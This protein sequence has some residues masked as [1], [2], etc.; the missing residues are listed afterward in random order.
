MWLCYRPVDREISRNFL[1]DPSQ[2]QVGHPCNKTIQNG[3]FPFSLEK[4]KILF[5]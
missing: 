2:R 5:L 4:N 3:V 1:V